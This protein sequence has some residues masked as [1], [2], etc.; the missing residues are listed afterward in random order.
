MAD[1][2]DMAY[3]NSLPQPLWAGTWGHNWPVYDICVQTGLM[4]L[5]VCGK[6]DITH[7]DKHITVKDATGKVHYTGDLYLDPENWE[8]RAALATNKSEVR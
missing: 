2:L 5:D 1:L 4:R 7:I 6:L 8:E 3:I